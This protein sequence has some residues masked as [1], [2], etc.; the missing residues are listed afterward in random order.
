L[1]LTPGAWTSIAS[2]EA[3]TEEGS[4]RPLRTTNRCPDS[5]T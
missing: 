3:S 1:S 2:A 5:P 4:A